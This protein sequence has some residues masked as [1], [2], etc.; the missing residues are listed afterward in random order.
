[1]MAHRLALTLGAVLFLI[2]VSAFASG[3]GTDRTLHDIG[4]ASPT[5]NGLGIGGNPVSATGPGMARASIY[6]LNAAAD[7][8]GNY[9]VTFRESGLV[10]GTLWSATLDG[11]TLFATAPHTVQFFPITNGSYPYAIPGIDGYTVSPFIGKIPVDG[12]NF[13]QAITFVPIVIS[14]FSV[15]FVESGLKSGTVWSATLNGT[16][17]FSTSNFISFSIV[18]GTFAFG[19]GT[20]NGYTVSPQYGTVTVNGSATSKYVTFATITFLGLA[21][22]EGY[23]VLSGLVAFGV[24]LAIAIVVFLFRRLRR[25]PRAPKPS[26]AAATT[27]PPTT[28]PPT[29]P[30]S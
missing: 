5:S 15:T 6:S 16:T 7:A 8:P 11:S 9:T 18:N 27:T 24:V 4:I 3:P 22:A 17:Q 2:T 12:K 30:P 23:A 19:I 1:M 28:P 20:V 21:P 14:T 29:S 26:P 13:T 25:R 10:S